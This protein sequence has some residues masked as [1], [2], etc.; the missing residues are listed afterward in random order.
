MCKVVPQCPNVELTVSIDYL[1]PGLSFLDPL[2]LHVREMYLAPNRCRGNWDSQTFEV[3]A[4]RIYK[5]KNV[6]FYRESTQDIQAMFA[7][8]K[9]ALNMLELGGLVFSLTHK[10]RNGNV[11]RQLKSSMSNLRELKFETYD[12]NQFH[13]YCSLLPGCKNLRRVFMVVY[14]RDP[15]QRLP[16]C[17]HTCHRL[18]N[19]AQQCKKQCTSISDRIL[20]T[21]EALGILTLL[22]TRKDSTLR[23]R[24]GSVCSDLPEM[25]LN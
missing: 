6:K 5:F 16:V 20:P 18:L 22:Y 25:K 10:N 4:D 17:Q 11:V 15:Y 8:P 7:T 9:L 12:W 3:C 24:V 2:A 14:A 1:F 23:G 19:A 13:S 21:A